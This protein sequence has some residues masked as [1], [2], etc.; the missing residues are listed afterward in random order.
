MA[1]NL[2]HMPPSRDALMDEIEAVRAARA[3]AV[4]A[5]RAAQ[6]EYTAADRVRK[7]A[8]RTVAEGG[9]GC[10]K[11][12]A[13]DALRFT[14]IHARQGLRRLASVADTGGYVFGADV[15]GE[16]R[17]LAERFERAVSHRR[18]L[19]RSLRSAPRAERLTFEEMGAAMGVSGEGVRY[20]TRESGR[21]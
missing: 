12:Q 17:E 5:L 3:E 13:A 11:D 14:G 20:L 19:V 7:R 18:E 2:T 16:L 9:V 21:S 15:L 10:T 6:T 1:S 4:R 8:A